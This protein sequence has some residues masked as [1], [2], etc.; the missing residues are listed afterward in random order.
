MSDLPVPF[1]STSPMITGHRGFLGRALFWEFEKMFLR[2]KR[3]K[4][5]PGSKGGPYAGW[6]YEG[7]DYPNHTIIW[8]DPYAP[9]VRA[10][11]KFD[12][13]EQ[14]E[15]SDSVIHCAAVAN[16]HDVEADPGKAA[17]INL[18]GTMNIAAA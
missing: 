9:K 12:V 17:R 8:P 2:D 13:F 1:I 10:V 11:T 18:E 5:D 6:K 4:N 16:L 3:D 7:F 15:D 14:V